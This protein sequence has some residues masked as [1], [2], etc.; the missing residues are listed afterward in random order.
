[1]EA[2][3]STDY[4]LLKETTL[5]PA[6]PLDAPRSAESVPVLATIA[7]AIKAAFGRFLERSWGNNEPG[8]W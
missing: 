6:L 5:N 1:M 2:K 7:Q 4:T 8:A 3:T